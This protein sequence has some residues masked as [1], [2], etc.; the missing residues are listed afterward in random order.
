MNVKILFLQNFII[1]EVGV[2]RGDGWGARHSSNS[3]LIIKFESSRVLK[4]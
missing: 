2:W 4:M 1:A 3:Q